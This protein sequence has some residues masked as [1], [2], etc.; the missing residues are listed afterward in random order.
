MNLSAGDFLGVW[1]FLGVNI[2]SPGP[3]VINTIA[4]AMGGG[5]RA[6]MGSALGVGLGIGIWCLGMSLGMGAVFAAVPQA[7]AVLTVVALGLLA[8]FARRYFAAAFAGWRGQ[9]R[10][11]PDRL[12]MMGM[13]AAFLRSLTVNA[14][15]PKALT[16][17]ITI[18]TLFPLARARGAD[19]VVLCAGACALSF[20]IH[21]GYTLLFSTAPAARFYLRWGWAI[22]AAAGCF[23]TAVG[24]KLALG[25][26]G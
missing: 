14:L 19:I 26:I 23:F 6:G 17:W 4:T 11:L 9:R 18:L 10:G 2:L 13:R 21:A 3:N 1:L 25:L 5:R 16:S 12:P 20:S 24:V 7:R 15:N 22:S 8:L